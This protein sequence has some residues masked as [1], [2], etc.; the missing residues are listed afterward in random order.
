MQPPNC[1]LVVGHTWWQFSTWY[2]VRGYIGYYFIVPNI[3]QTYQY[4]VPGMVQQ[5]VWILYV[6]YWYAYLIVC[7]YHTCKVHTFLYYYIITLLPGTN[8]CT[9]R[10]Y[11]WDSREGNSVQRR[12]W[13]QHRPLHAARAAVV[14][15]MSIPGTHYAWYTIPGYI[16]VYPKYTNA[17]KFP[18]R[19]Q[20]VLLILESPRLSS[21]FHYRRVVRWKVVILQLL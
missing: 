1:R 16:H 20:A 2:L 17:H 13:F 19:A 21:R 3:V 6:E 11:P 5:H 18:T 4:Q 12:W 9:G 7:M 8:C 14:Y 15:G 10:Y